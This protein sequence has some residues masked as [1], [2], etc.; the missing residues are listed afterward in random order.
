MYYYLIIVG[1]IITLFAQIYVQSSY[2]KYS[3]VKNKKGISGSE[4]AR[5][6][7]KAN[8]LDNI[9]V[10][11]TKGILSDHY[12]PSAKVIR[13][14][15]DIY[16]GESIAAA[17]V[18]AHEVGHAI[19]HKEGYGFLKFRSM[20]LPLANIGNK[21]GYFAIMIGLIFNFLDLAFVGLFLLLF[22]LAFQLVTL[23]VEFDASK[24]AGVSLDKMQILYADEM[25]KSKKMLRAAAY[26]YV[27]SLVTTLLEVFRMFL[28]VNSRRD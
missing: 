16:N 6:I 14:S 3:K 13:L 28:I 17:S 15:K 8:G 1:F 23:P 12:D 7:L 18:A 9:Y 2:T 11:E 10:V 25:P 5:E 21:F 19:Q 26:T 20:L 22:I 4:V 24:R 27:A